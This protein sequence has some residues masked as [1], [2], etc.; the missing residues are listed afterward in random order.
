[1]SGRCKSCDDALSE[2]EIVWYEE[3]KEHE[4]LCS[5]CLKRLNKDLE[6]NLLLLSDDAEE[7]I[8]FI[9]YNEET[10]YE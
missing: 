4:H 5:G 1:M 8:D 2:A 9:P 3:L 6:E 10:N 7:A